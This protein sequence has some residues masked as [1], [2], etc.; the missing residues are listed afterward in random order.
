MN[1]NAV[2]AIMGPTCAGK[3]GL[4]MALAREFPVALISVD[5]AQVYRGMD[6]GTAKPDA[7][8]LLQY[9]HALIDICEPTEPYNAADFCRDARAC[10]AQAHAQ[11]KIPVLVGGTMMYFSALLGGLSDLPESDPAM[12]AAVLAEAENLGWPAMHAQLSQLDPLIAERIKPNDAQ[13]IGRALE[14]CRMTGEPM[15]RLQAQPADPFPYPHHLIGLMPSDRARLHADIAQRFNDMLSQGFLDE[16]KLLFSKSGIEPSLPAI[17]S[18]GYRQ[19]WEFLQGEIDEPTFKA[20]SVAATRQLAKRQMT[21]LR[22][23][24]NCTLYDPYDDGDLT[25]LRQEL[26]IFLSKI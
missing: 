23:W 21:W 22:A 17:K 20:K 19:A 18:V 11:G 25:R 4:A 10:I 6:I 3:T 16:A 26:A 9:P 13:R 12:R 1:K 2:I 24:K 5:S 14:V 7:A 8:T 15:S